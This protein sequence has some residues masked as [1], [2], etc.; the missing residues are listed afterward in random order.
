MS[1]FYYITVST[2]PHPILELLEKSVKEKKEKVDILG[3]ELNKSIGWN[4]ET[5]T[6]HFGLKLRLFW[7][8][9]MHPRLNKNDIVLFSDAFDVL[10]FGT[11]KEIIKRYLEFNKPIV[12]GAEAGCWPDPSVKKKY[13]DTSHRFSF[14]NSGLFIGRV[15]AFRELHADYKFNDAEDDQRYW[16]KKYLSRPSLFA[17][18][19][20]NKLFLN[21]YTVKKEEINIVSKSC[22]KFGK[23][24][25]M[26]LHFNG[27][28][29]STLLEPHFAREYMSK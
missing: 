18:D 23:A 22:A 13:K 11:Q 10:Y 14:L 24:T 26:F 20:N 1:N 6:G 3:I 2:K 12:F 16:T 25:P 17:L 28:T 9:V 19:Y 15:W 29:K 4:G 8:Y 5:S 7:E 27:D 21:C